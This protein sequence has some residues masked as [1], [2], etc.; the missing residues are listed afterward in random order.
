MLKKQSWLVSISTY[1]A[2]CGTVTILYNRSVREKGERSRRARID[3][4]GGVRLKTEPGGF[5]CVANVKKSI[6]YRITKYKLLL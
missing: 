6:A 5:T 1:A 2:V 4:E 3:W